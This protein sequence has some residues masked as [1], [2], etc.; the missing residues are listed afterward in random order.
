MTNFGHFFREFWYFLYRNRRWWVMPL[1][2]VLL[3][4]GMLMVLSGP[5]A[6]PFVYR[7]F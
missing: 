7:I 2:V 3:L 6:T 4:V 1:I 5:A